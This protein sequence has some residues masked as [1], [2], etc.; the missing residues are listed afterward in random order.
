MLSDANVMRADPS[1]AIL[2][3]RLPTTEIQA[4]CIPVYVTFWR[5]VP[6]ETRLLGRGTM[7]KA[8]NQAGEWRCR[9]YR[10]SSAVQVGRRR[11]QP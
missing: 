5:G 6:L 1:P 3:A 2:T 9:K 8:L 10:R 7:I 4:Y 11:I